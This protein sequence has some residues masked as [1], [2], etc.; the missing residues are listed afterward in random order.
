[1]TETHFMRALHYMLMI[2][3]TLHTCDTYIARDNSVYLLSRV[4]SGGA[5]F[6]LTSLSVSLLV[7]ISR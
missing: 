3:L 4:T 7:I 2:H 5:S 6:L 1:M